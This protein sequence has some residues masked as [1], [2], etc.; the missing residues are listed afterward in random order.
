[1]KESKLENK[2]RTPAHQ[3]K[4]MSVSE[5]TFSVWH[6]LTTLVIIGFLVYSNSF[7]CS[8]HLDDVSSIT[9]NTKIRNIN[10]IGGLWTE[11]RSRFFAYVT[12]ALNYH[13][14]ELDV[15]GY[16]F[17]NILIHIANA[18]LVYFL[19]LQIF[20][21]PSIKNHPTATNSKLIAFFAALIF[22]SH[23]LATSSVTYIVQ[24]M[25]SLV[26]F[27]YLISV[28]LYIKGRSTGQG[29]RKKYVYFILAVAFAFMA[30]FTKENA[31]TLPLSILLCELFLL[32]TAPLIG[33]AGI[34]K[35]LIAVPFLV[36]LGYFLFNTYSLSVFQPIPPDSQNNFQTITSSGYLYTQFFVVLKY[37]QLFVLPLNQNIDYDIAVSGGLLELRTIFSFIG[38]SALVV[39]AIWLYKKNR[40]WSFCL[41]WIFITISIESSVIPISDV[42]FEHRT[43]LP[44]LGYSLL[45]CLVIFEIDK[46]VDKPMAT[47][48]LVLIVIFFSVLTFRRN[49]VYKDDLTFWTDAVEK[50]PKKVRPLNFRGAEHYKSSRYN[51]AISDFTK[52]IELNPDFHI[53]YFNR[54]ACY[55][56]MGKYNEAIRDYEMSI[57][58]ESAFPL[59][60]AEGYFYRGVTYSLI[61]DWTKAADN[62]RK[63]VALNPEYKD[64]WYNL[65]VAL[66]ELKEW[67]NAIQAFTESIKRSPTFASNYTNRGVCYENTGQWSN[68]I[69][70]YEQAVKINPSEITAVKNLELAKRRVRA[71][72]KL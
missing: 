24:R 61:K 12:F 18:F 22:I 5:N 23:P 48:L 57:E 37:F 69:A 28:L 41:F 7:N 30:F 56:K 25:A 2:H 9:E 38:L 59:R 63:L 8:F 43:Y 39:W 13:Y 21:T 3:S 55:R 14:G 67:D 10:E 50:S 53:L 15:R 11:F 72:P 6:V 32:Q 46:L 45:F 65:G 36:A 33:A 51:E 49:T 66:A 42:I 68:A 58:S 27:F 4:P 26:T 16:H 31:F 29:E 40:L 52:A 60:A 47:K 34:R 71:S 62:F 70:D 44:S 19:S 1:M 64:S 35:L 20:Q 54:G 17:I